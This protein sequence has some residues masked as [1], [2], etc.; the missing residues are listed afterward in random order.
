MAFSKIVQN[1]M[2][3]NGFDCCA[4]SCLCVSVKFSVLERLGI[5]MV[6]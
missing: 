4:C 3:E 2:H 6:L 5:S 1:K